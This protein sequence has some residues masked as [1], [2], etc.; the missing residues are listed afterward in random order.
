ME[1]VIVAAAVVWLFIVVSVIVDVVRRRDLSGGATALW[2]VAIVV[3]PLIGV[4]AYLLM[5]PD[6]SGDE[7]PDVAAYEAKVV[8]DGED[9]AARIAELARQHA[10]GEISDDEYQ[11]LRAE[12]DPSGNELG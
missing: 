10:E 6:V 4:V 7:A 3:V 5:R 12:L 1:I 8:S 9:L 11:R 2:C